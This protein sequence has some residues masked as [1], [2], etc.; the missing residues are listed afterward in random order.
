MFQCFIYYSFDWVTSNV[1]LTIGFSADIFINACLFNSLR[2]GRGLIFTICRWRMK[3]RQRLADSCWSRSDGAISGTSQME[4]KPIGHIC[5]SPCSLCDHTG[6][7]QGQTRRVT[8]TH[9]CCRSTSGRFICQ[10]SCVQDA[11]A[12]P[13]CLCLVSCEKR[14]CSGLDLMMM[15]TSAGTSPLHTPPPPRLETPCQV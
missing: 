7:G 3:P 13:A 12:A 8:A 10:S 5:T 2:H 15:S 11:V 14:L 6:P 1:L 9:V 4:G